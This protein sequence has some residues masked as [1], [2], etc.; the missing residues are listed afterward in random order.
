LGD[1][2]RQR[3]RNYAGHLYLKD[4]YGYKVSSLDSGRVFRLAVSEAWGAIRLLWTLSA[5]AS[6]EYFSRILGAYD[7]YV[8]RKRHEIWDIAWTTKQ[9]QPPPPGGGLKQALD[10]RTE[11]PHFEGR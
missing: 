7:Y 4:K 9:V 8:K 2:I 1:F 5:L 3:R 6:V 11:R 10:Q